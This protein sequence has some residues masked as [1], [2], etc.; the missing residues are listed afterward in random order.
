AQGGGAP[1][2]FGG[3]RRGGGRW[4]LSVYHTW[5]FSE[6][7]R[8]APGAAVLDQL[9]GDSLTSG[10]VPRHRIEAE[11][12]FFLDGIG[13][14]LNATWN[15]P[16]SVNGSGA[17][18]SSD[19]RF[20][21]YTTAKLRL[22]VDLDQRASLIAKAPFL[23]GSRIAFKVDNLFDSRQKVTDDSGATPIAYQRAYREPLGRVIGID[24]R[25]MF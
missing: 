1:P 2:M 21:A 10:G 15:A 12:G 3:N 17:P 9:S 19:L 13:L 18:G 25:K 16:A 22:F 7:V 24:F 14:R 4:N 23:K 20:G 11:G 5:R 6:D 8:I